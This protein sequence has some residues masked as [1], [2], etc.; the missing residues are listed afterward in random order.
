MSSVNNPV[1]SEFLSA[2]RQPTILGY[3]DQRLV[4][5][6]NSSKEKVHPQGNGI[7]STKR[8]AENSAAFLSHLI[9][10]LEHFLKIRRLDPKAIQKNVQVIKNPSDLIQ[11]FAKADGIRI[12]DRRALKFYEMRLRA[13]FE[14][15][16]SA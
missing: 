11:I 10:K 5:R 16:H 14:R 2:A 12:T 1:P 6:R 13:E 7:A 3:L 8:D 15:S 9:Q 4:D